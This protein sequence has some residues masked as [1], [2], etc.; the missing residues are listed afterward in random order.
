[1]P[2]TRGQLIQRGPK[3]WLIR[4]FEGRVEGKRKHANY[5]FYGPR[6]K[7]VQLRD[8]LQRERD[9]L[10]KELAS[11]DLL[12]RLVKCELTGEEANLALLAFDRVFGCDQQGQVTGK[13]RVR[14]YGYTLEAA[15]QLRNK[16]F[17]HHQHPKDTP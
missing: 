12:S 13:K 3:T 1:M 6:S 16:L 4:I 14:R 10:R 8:R 7:A 9:D 2:R 5:T 17:S 15:Q 11:E